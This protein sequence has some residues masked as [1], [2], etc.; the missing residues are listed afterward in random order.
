M[1]DGYQ[2]KNRLSSI[3]SPVEGSDQLTADQKS[4]ALL[5]VMQYGSGYNNISDCFS[6]SL[7]TGWN[8]G[9]LWLDYTNDP[10]D[11]DIVFGREPFSGFIVD[12]YFTKLDFSDCGYIIKRKYL[13]P[14]RAAALVPTKRKE[15]MELGKKAYPKDGKFSWLPY[16]RN[17]NSQDMVSYSEL[18]IQKYENVPML[19]DEESGQFTELDKNRG[20]AKILLELYPKLKEVQRPKRYIERHVIVN[21][22]RVLTER[23]PYGLDEYPFVPFVSIFESESDDF[24]LKIQSLVRCQIDPQRESNKRRSQF[25]D[26]V[27]SQLNSGWLAEEDSVINPRSLFQTGQ[28]KV[29]WKKQGLTPGAIEK[30]PAAQ[31]PPSLFQLQ[32][33]FDRD[34]VDILGI[35]DA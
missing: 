13:S 25:I 6:A 5:Y 23:D 24:S 28:G 20:R 19:V 8:L 1:I 16:E 15:I 10:L 31:I 3:V 7:K 34:M 11:G 9:S 18:Y 12:P 14:D 30:I 35:N 22:E 21:R 32:E 2:R 4:Q 27:D 29:I 26:M 33:L 17:T